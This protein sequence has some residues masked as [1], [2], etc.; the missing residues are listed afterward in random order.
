MGGLLQGGLYLGELFGVRVRAH[1]SMLAVLAIGASG[2]ALTGLIFLILFLTVLLHELCHCFAARALGG[3]ARE[4]LLWPLG[5]LAFTGGVRSPAGSIVVAAAGPLVHIPLALGLGLALARMGHPLTLAD[6]NPLGVE[7]YPQSSMLANLLYFSFRLQLE[8]FCL[9][10]LPAYP[11]DGGQILVGWLAT[12]FELPRAAT[13]CGLLSV[14]LAV[15]LITLGGGYV[16]IGA[17][18]GFEGARLLMA[19][20]SGGIDWHPLARLYAS[21]RVIAPQAPR[22]RVQEEYLRP[23]PHCHKPIHQMAERC[24]HC[25]HLVET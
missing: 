23:C 8:L 25:D 14:G 24:S 13:I 19:V 3:E 16:L 1:W 4:I 20:Q 6:F 5:G 12:R 18:L 10:M 9:N 17:L 22:P 2:G 7:S 15:G 21:A 11:L